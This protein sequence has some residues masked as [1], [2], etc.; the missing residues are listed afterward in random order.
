MQRIQRIKIFKKGIRTRCLSLIL[1]LMTVSFTALA[2][3]D[4]SQFYGTIDRYYPIQKSLPYRIQRVEPLP[5]RPERPPRT[6]PQ[7]RKITAPA[8]VNSLE[9]RTEQANLPPLTKD[10]NAAIIGV[11]GDTLADLLGHGLTDAFAERRDW[12]VKRKTKADSGLV[13]S[14]FYD[15][16][17][18]LKDI[19]ASEKPMAYAVIMMG[20]NDRQILREGE[21][22]L[23]PLSARWKEVY[24]A[25]IDAMISPFLDKK[26]PILWVG[27]PPMRSEKLST[28]LSAL[29][30]MFRER[31]EKAG[32]TY[33]DLWE[34]F[35]D[36]QNRFAPSGPDY[37]G[38]IAK[39]RTADGIHFTKAGSRKAAHFVDVALRR[40]MD[41]KPDNSLPI[42]LPIIA[43]A[44][45]IQEDVIAKRIDAMLSGIPQPFIP[46][47]IPRPMAGPIFPLTKSSPNNTS[48]LTT[49]PAYAN[50]TAFINQ[51]VLD[52]GLPPPARKGRADDFQWK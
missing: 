45:I 14:D 8:S 39:L 46:T 34:A 27:L 13:R 21:A 1:I 41:L 9:G 47:L 23:E 16:P 22:T 38:Q 31:V 50:E 20:L 11:Y 24:I 2:E 51:R 12:D 19:L 33:I 35:S 29:N 48:L 5:I 4:S 15:W 18:A 32:G 36:D 49:R 42:S 26:I 37:S 3:N 10:A 43:P 44:S 17:K 28:D 40:M 52:Q 6:A 30:T 7:P 25:R